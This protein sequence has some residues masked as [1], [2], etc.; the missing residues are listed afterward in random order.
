MHHGSYSQAQHLAAGRL[1]ALDPRLMQ[2]QPCQDGESS[3]SEE[4][5][6]GDA[7]PPME[8]SPSNVV[9]AAAPPAPPAPR[10][11]RDVALHILKAAQIPVERAGEALDAV[12]ANP[13]P[14]VN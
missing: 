3:Y 1:R 14:E 10:D 13:D 2:Y 11:P 4:D 9:P 8:P 5:Y 7:T 6:S 12:E